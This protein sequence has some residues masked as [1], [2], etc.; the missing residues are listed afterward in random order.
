MGA[1]F[2]HNILT[3]PRADRLDG[4]VLVATHRQRQGLPRHAHFVRAQSAR[5]ER[6]RADRVLDLARRASTTRA[7]RCSPA[8]ATWRWPAASPSKFRTRAGTCSRRARSSRP[9]VTAAPS[10]S[11]R[12]A[13]C[14]AAVPASWCCGACATPCADGDRIY[15]VIKGSA[16]NNDGAGKV[17]YLAP[18]VDGQAAAVAE[19]LAVAGVGADSIGYVEC[20]GTG[21]R[22]RRSDRGRRAHLGVPRNHRRARLTARSVRSRRTSATSTRRRAWRA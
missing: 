1:Y 22:G 9:T 10:I 15:A 13:P 5:S 19:A 21:H 4:A 8:S 3:Q 12:P 6:R 16:V 7:S 17:G 18:S 14:S 2:A 11:A 20:H